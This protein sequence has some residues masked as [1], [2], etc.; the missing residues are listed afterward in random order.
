MLIF[1]IAD[2]ELARHSILGRILAAGE[3][4]AEVLFV[5]DPVY[6]QTKQ[7]TVIEGFQAALFLRQF[8][9]GGDQQTHGNGN[10]LFPVA[11][12]MFVDDGEQGIENGRA[13]FPDFVQKD[14][15]GIRQIPF[16]QAQ[17][18]PLIL[19]CLD[20]EGAEYLFGGGEAGHQV[21]EGLALVE[22]MDQAASQQALGNTGR[23]EHEDAFATKGSQQAQAHDILALEESLG[24]GINQLA[25]AIG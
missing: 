8:I 6:P 11:E 23:A 18:T 16:N 21:F 5:L 19:Q 14:H 24:K 10:F 13:R 1:V 7:H 4:G 12:F 2:L 17:I 9:G 25:N 15:F 3:H 20:G 22:G